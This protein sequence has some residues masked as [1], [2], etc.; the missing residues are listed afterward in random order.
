MHEHECISADRNRLRRRLAVVVDE[1]WPDPVRL[2]AI[3][4]V[5]GVLSANNPLRRM[6]SEMLL[7][8]MK[9]S[10]GM[11]LEVVRGRTLERPVRRPPQALSDV[12]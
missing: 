8:S 11:R 7:E 2:A 4:A 3:R 5:Q 6:T 1:R 9:P 12:W 10:W